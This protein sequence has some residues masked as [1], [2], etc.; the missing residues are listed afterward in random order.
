MPAPAP[1]LLITRAGGAAGQQTAF[2]G[3]QHPRLRKILAISPGD[4]D[5]MQ[6]FFA[7]KCV[8]DG[9]PPFGAGLCPGHQV[10]CFSPSW[11]MAAR[12]CWARFFGRQRQTGRDSSSRDRADAP[13]KP[14]GDGRAM[15]WSGVAAEYLLSRRR[16]NALGVPRT[17]C[18]CRCTDGRDCLTAKPP[19]RRGA[20]PAWPQAISASAPFSN[21]PPRARISKGLQ[22]LYAHRRRRDHYPQAETPCPNAWIQ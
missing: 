12:C 1:R 15:A 7:R 11:V 18:A 13:S 10:R 19:A 16:V 14:D 8:P 2:A 5:D 6:Q 3:P 20:E 17:A 21:F 9:A 22:A 4:P